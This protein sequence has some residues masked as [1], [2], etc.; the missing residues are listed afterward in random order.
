MSEFKV[1]VVKI[2][3]VER[4]PNSDNLSITMVHGGYP[5]IF[6]T[7][8]FKEGDLA[9][10]VPV[11]SIMPNTPEWE[12]LGTSKRIK[13]KRLRGVF[14]MGML[15]KAQAGWSEGQNVQKELGITKWE[16][17]GT[18]QLESAQGKKKR[19]AWE[20]FIIYCCKY[21]YLRW[22]VKPAKWITPQKD[23]SKYLPE[24]TDIEGYRKHTNLLQDGEEVVCTEKL[25]GTNCAY[26]YAKVGPLR[27]GT[28]LL[29]SHHQLRKL[30]DGSVWDNVAQQYDLPNKMKQYPG[31][32]IYGEIVGKVQKGFD[33]GFGQKYALR[34][35]DI[36]DIKTG[37]Y[38]NYQAA[39]VIIA[40]LGLERV[41]ELY[42]G[43]WSKDVLKLANGKTTVDKANHIREG[44][45]VKPLVERT[46]KIGRVILKVI[47]E[48]YLLNKKG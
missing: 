22:L 16:D 32:A 47:G 24:Y 20:N 29:R 4:L 1:E 14:S 17:E 48:E 31:L 13:A 38:M 19:T 35:F 41:P 33:Y 7:V 43:P 40:G 26:V 27:K 21:W 42:K 2:G 12:F 3:E 18:V 6:K 37:K 23:L 11:D 39:S 34:V 15:V 8:D 28:F 36:L 46:A 10:Y 30:G 9:V 25:H 44:F 5:V 45:V